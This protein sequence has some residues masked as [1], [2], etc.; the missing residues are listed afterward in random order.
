MCP[1]AASARARAA[2]SSRL[3][4]QV[5]DRGPGEDARDEG[6]ET[7]A[8]VHYRLQ[9]T[10]NAKTSIISSPRVSTPSEDG[11]LGRDGRHFLGEAEHPRD[12]GVSFL[13][14]VRDKVI[15][16]VVKYAA[17][18]G[19]LPSGPD[20][21][22]ILRVRGPPLVLPVCRPLEAG[23]RSA[24]AGESVHRDPQRAERRVRSV[25]SRWLLAFIRASVSS[26]FTVRAPQ[27]VAAAAGARPPRAPPPR[28]DGS[29]PTV[30][31]KAHIKP[32]AQAKGKAKARSLF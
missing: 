24:S 3:R 31:R 22:D 17:A 13:Q 30:S 32:K 21:S 16:E 9:A 10:S 20:K 11:E 26:I 27:K 23:A 25:Q 4:P 12:G 15:Q 8:Y 5:A 14:A 19:L 29:G 1:P 18:P 28:Q 2:L 7:Y 6:Q